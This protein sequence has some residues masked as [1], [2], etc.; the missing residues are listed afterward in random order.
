MPATIA[1]QVAAHP[2]IDLQYARAAWRSLRGLTRPVWLVGVGAPHRSR[3]HAPVDRRG[4]RRAARSRD[5]RGRRRGGHD[6]L[7]HRP[8]VRPDNERLLARAPPQRAARRRGTDRD[9]GR[10]D[11]ARRRVGP[12]RSR[13][14]D[15]RRLRGEPRRSRRPADRPLPVHAPDPRTPWRTSVRALARLVDDGLVSSV[16]LAN[17]NRRQLDEALELAPVAAVQV[18]LSPYDDRALRGGVVERCAETG[19]AVL[20][21]SPL[22]GPRRAGGLARHQ[23]LAEIA[24]ARGATPAEVAL[25]WLLDALPHRRRDPR[26][27][28][29]GDRALRRPRRDARPRRRRPRRSRA[30]VRQAPPAPARRNRARRDGEVVLVMGIPGAGKSRIAEEYVA[31]GYLRLN[32]DERGGS[33]RD[34]ADA[35]DEE[36]AAGARRIVLDNT[37]LTRAARSYVD[38]RGGPPRRSRRGASGSTRRSRRRRSTS[39]SGCSS[40]SARSRRPRS[41]GR[42][43]GASRACSRPRPRCARSASSSRRRPTRASRRRAG[44]PSC[45]RRRRN[46]AGRCLRRGGRARAARLGGGA[47]GGAIA[48]APHLVFDWSPDGSRA[49]CGRRRPRSR[50]RSPA[51]SSARCARMPAARR[52]AGAGHRCR[53]CR[54]R[55]RERT[56]STRRA[57]Y[58]SAPARRTG[59]SRRRSAPATSRSELGA[60]LCLVAALVDERRRWALAPAVPGRLHALHRRRLLARVRRIPVDITIRERPRGEPVREHR[61]ADRRDHGEQQGALVGER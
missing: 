9:E 31:R 18:A 34:L 36:L 4:P 49:T 30:C 43:R 41:C 21:H 39:S 14:D 42:W 50:P 25:A 51:R 37:Y 32:R 38:R 11:A 24:A 59:R 61:H 10:D 19:I 40:A 57:R 12:G 33:L 7:R 58:S 56:A 17:V 6:R 52:A 5:D 55:S 47:R 23:A 54:S 44:C 48:S 22:G 8:L 1:I 3:L 15:P 53:G 35:L 60:R 46:V 29:P 45:A 16:G 20:A 13:E 2:R 28:A 26:R 27:A